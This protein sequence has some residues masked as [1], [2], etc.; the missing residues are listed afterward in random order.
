MFALPHHVAT[1]DS[2]TAAKKKTALTFSSP[3]KGTMTAIISNT[4]TMTE[5]EMPV[6]IGWLPVKSGA[7]PT[8][9]SAY[10]TQQSN[11]AIT[12]MAQDMNAMTNLDTM[13]FSGKALA[14]Y[15]YICLSFS[16]VLNDPVNARACIAKLKPAFERFNSNTQIHPLVYESNVWRGLITSAVYATGDVNSDFGSGV[17]N[18]HHFH[19]SY[20]VQ[21]AGI[22]GY[23]D[24]KLNGGTTTWI[25]S[26]KSFVN[27]LIRDAC[28]PSPSDTY[29]P[30]F[31]SFDWF[32]G[33]SWAKGVTESWDGKD[34]ES[35]SEDANFYYSMKMWG[36]L[37]GDAA[38]EARGNLMLS[39]LKRSVNSYMQLLSSN[40]N[41]P[42]NFVQNKVSGIMFEN[43]V[44]HTTY[45]GANTEYIQGIHMLPLTAISPY[46]RPAAFVIEEW[47]KYW[48]GGAATFAINDGL[49]LIHI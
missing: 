16:E 18:D 40:T 1:F 45:F 27:T 46:M 41:H 4:W 12:E 10:L 13:Y 15:A 33:H 31:R 30:Q 37:I 29:F 17:Y 34:E 11:I 39:I 20:F 43:K 3:T 14:K 6:N 2:A 25:N 42:S 48:P 19:Y 24:K 22:I 35:S 7:A 49:S 28:N 9:Q 38:M 32:H 21:T 47:N 44:H 36:N 8:F 5:S 26:V 23:L